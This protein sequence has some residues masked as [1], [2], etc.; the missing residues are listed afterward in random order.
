MFSRFYYTYRILDEDKGDSGKI[1]KLNFQYAIFKKAFFA[2][3][4]E[5]LR[6][7]CGHN[8]TAKSMVNIVGCINSRA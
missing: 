5:F 1:S 7:E 6:Q 2:T 3:N 4:S 8:A